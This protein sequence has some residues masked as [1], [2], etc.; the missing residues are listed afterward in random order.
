MADKQLNIM[1]ELEGRPLGMQLLEP[2]R[3]YVKPV[4]ECLSQIAIKALSHITGGGLIENLPRV[5]PKGMQAGIDLTSWQ[6]QPLFDLLQRL[7][8]LS[9]LEMH[10]TFNCGIGMVLCVAPEQ[11]DRAL[12]LL[13]TQG[14]L[15]WLIGRVEAQSGEQRVVLRD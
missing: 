10:T 7:G 6:R 5:L 15:A 11:A 2:T 12:Q 13:Q 4:R 8:G 3:I 9:Q 14:E 1:E